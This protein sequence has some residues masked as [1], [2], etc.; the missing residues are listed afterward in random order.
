MACLP[1]AHARAHD[2]SFFF[3]F[4]LKSLFL[5]G[6]VRQGLNQ[7]PSF[8]DFSFV[9]RLVCCPDA[10]SSHSGNTAMSLDGGVSMTM[11]VCLCIYME[12]LN[13]FYRVSFTAVAPSSLSSSLFSGND[14]PFANERRCI[15]TEPRPSPIPRVA[16]ARNH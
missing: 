12:G 10:P 16:C 3:F 8:P 6:V 5:C 2:S 15:I 14:G 7:L 11:T 4:F 9:R 1:G 13:T